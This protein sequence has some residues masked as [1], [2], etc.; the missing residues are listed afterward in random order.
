MKNK[1]FVKNVEPIPTPPA[2]HIPGTIERI[3]ISLEDLEKLRGEG[4]NIP[5]DEELRKKFFEKP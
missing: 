3:Y 2:S 4:Y 1:P 5:S